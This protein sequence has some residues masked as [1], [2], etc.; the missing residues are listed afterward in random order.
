MIG[1]WSK[2]CLFFLNSFTPGILFLI[3]IFQNR[4]CF[5]TLDGHEAT[6]W[7]ISFNHTGDRLGW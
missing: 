4:S 2:P 1:H 5:D 3:C 6:V 7:A